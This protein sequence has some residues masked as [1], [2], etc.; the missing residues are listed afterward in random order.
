[1]ALELYNT[2]SRSIEQFQPLDSGKVGFYGCGPTVYNYAHI[3]NLRA[4]V[5]Q[6]T[7]TR[8]L[9]FLGYDV[10]H[11]MNITDI[12]HLA[13]DADDGEDKMVKTA[14]ERG[15]SVLEI[16]EYY[17]DAFFRDTEQLNIIRP[18]VVCKATEHIPQMIDLIKRIEAN[19][20]TYMAGGNLYYDIST[21][22]DYGKLARL[23]LNDLKAGARI[24]IDENKR[25]PY[26]FVLWFTK[27]KFENQALTWDSPWGRG[28]P[29]WHIEC[30]AM[31]MYYLGEQFDIHTGGI[32]H[33]PIHHTNEIAQSEGAT[34][35]KWVYYWLHN[36]FLVMSKGK[37]SKSS[38]N[39]ITLQTIIDEG[40]EALDYRY[41]LLGGHYRNQLAFS[42]ESMNS[43]KNSRRSLLQ[44]IKK[45]I[46][47]AGNTD[48]SSGDFT[49][50]ENTPASVYA[51]R[52]K[53]HIEQDLNTPRALS[54]LQALLR[55]PDIS[56]EHILQGIALMDTVLGLNLITEARKS[57]TEQNS[58]AASDEDN[59]FI[60]E[61][62]AERTEAKQTKNW[63]R[64]DEIRNLLRE[65]G[66]I[67]E[68]TPS[69]T[70]WRRS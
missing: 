39:F 44:R 4:Y 64:A 30:S 58:A 5:F 54:E 28:Y 27:S 70:I 2:M 63:T 21:F 15:K 56:P 42:W 41:F 6:D 55:A 50:L 61:L 16:A 33:I 59:T 62:V 26:D 65:K 67:L 1:M 57:I 29:G 36:E 10:A 8:A 32:D 45:L 60:E 11:V 9:R 52:F 69:G 14:E 37:M 22:P 51:E 12:G 49:S 43:A 68:D 23:D 40:Y 34:G 24:E 19:G 3:G 53:S 66:I 35:K 47:S 38:G 18:S 20:H 48:F 31:S 25:N 7:L 46:E 13:D 17:T